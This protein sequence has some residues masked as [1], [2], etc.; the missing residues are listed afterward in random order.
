MTEKSAP[1]KKKSPVLEWTIAIVVA[2]LLAFSIRVFIFEPYVVDGDS[3]DP[4]LKN[5]EKLFVNKAIHYIGEFKRGDI[6]I[7]NGKENK[8]HYVKRIIGLPGDTVEVKNDVLYVN[9]K[10][11]KEPYLNSNRKAAEASGLQLTNDFSEVK[12]PKDRYFVMGDNRLVSMD[13]R[14]G[15]GL[16]EVNRVIGKSEFVMLPFNKVRATN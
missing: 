4:T 9:G 16:I 11:V 5:S 13:S 2:V 3:M 12:V 10:E 6:V 8:E 15:L 1:K 7:I 14:T